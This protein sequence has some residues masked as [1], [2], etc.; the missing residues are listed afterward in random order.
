ME[1]VEEEVQ[2]RSCRQR[3]SAGTAAA[4]ATAL[5]FAFTAAPPLGLTFTVGAVLRPLAT[6][7]SVAPATGLRGHRWK[8]RLQTHSAVQMELVEEEVQGRATIINATGEIVQP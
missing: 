7:A 1:L 2:G 4:A 3:G 8:E 5:S 6:A